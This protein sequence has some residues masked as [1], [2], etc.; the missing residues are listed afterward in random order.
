[1]KL[2]STRVDDALKED[3]NNAVAWMQANVDEAFTFQDLM[4]RALTRELERL[5][6]KHNDGK[7]FKGNGTLRTGPAPI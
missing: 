3:A 4:T 5:E 1:M 6:K 2:I 7:P